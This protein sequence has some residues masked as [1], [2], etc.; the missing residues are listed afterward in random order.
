MSRAKLKRISRLV[1]LRERDRDLAQAK[2]AEAVRGTAS[3]RV[4][5]DAAREAWRVEAEAAAATN[6]IQV[7]EFALLRAHLRS[8]Q[9]A[10]ELATRRLADA[11]GRER[12]ARDATTLAQRELR[13]MEL[14]HETE[15]ARE[16]AEANRRD[17][18]TTD[19]FAARI[20]Q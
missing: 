20:M 1:G 16:L 15:S 18:A 14:W 4:A 8:L 17:Q 3:A 11:E 19:E 10:V 9:R 5:L 13:K 2:L 6:T 7:S 12:E